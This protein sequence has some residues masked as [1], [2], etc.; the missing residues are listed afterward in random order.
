MGAAPSRPHWLG[1]LLYVPLLYAGGWL[2]SRPPVLLLPGL[3]S[4]QGD[5]IAALIALVLLLLSLPWRLRRAWGE[6]APWRR[7]GL[8]AAAAP[9]L[10]ALLR[11]WLKAVL[12]L[13][14]VGAGLLLSGQARWGHTPTAAA[15]ANALLLG[16]G[17]GFAE[18]LV[19]RGWLWG[20]LELRLNP[21]TALML[22]ATVFG[23]VHPWAAAGGL[24]AVELLGGLILLGVA[25]ALQRR[26]DH[27]V[28]WGS[29]GLHGGLV[30]GWFLLQSG[31]LQLIPDAAAWLA[32][33]GGAQANPIGG[34]LGW[35][36][37]LL[38]ILVRRPWW[39]LNPAAAG[40]AAIDS[41]R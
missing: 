37:L 2:L 12:L 31:P 14:L 33:P 24:A 27:G 34:L 25:L 32:G 13:L 16:A 41:P 20:E 11:G 22:Q 35:L 8:A 10:K 23:L 36:G 28:L 18:E 17:V 9:I 29:V 30:G 15:C 19:F 1:T 39:R 3:R 5:L 4:D 26:A 7:L 6:P 38:L 21:A 40:Q